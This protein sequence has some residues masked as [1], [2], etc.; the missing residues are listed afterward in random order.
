MTKANFLQLHTLTPYPATLLNRDDAGFAKRLPFG[1]RSRIRI[2]SQC[3]K[4]HWRS[5]DKEGSLREL[6]AGMSVRSRHIFDRLIATPLIDE[7][8]A[9]E[10]VRAVVTVLRDELLGKSEKKKKKTEK[11]EEDAAEALA[12]GQIIVLGEPEIA[13]L[14]DA[15]RKLVQEED[16]KE[17]IKNAKGFLKKEKKNLAALKAAA[18]LDAALFGRMVTS[19]LLARGNAAVHVAHA[20][21]V[22]AEEVES[23]YFSAVDELVAAAQELGSGH[24]GETELTSGLFYSYVVVD[25][26]LLV[27]NLS[28]DVELAAQVVERLPS[29]MATVSP[30]AKKG[31]TAPYAYSQM[32]LAELGA[33]QPR[34]LANAFLDPIS[35]K[36]G[37]VVARSMDVLRE[38]LSGYDRM[39]GK[40]EERRVA[41]LLEP[42]NFPAATASSVAELSSWIGENVR[43]S[44]REE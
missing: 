13:F 4:K 25:L 19:D 29:I 32:V 26:A 27:R 21:T 16:P 5:F 14:L 23:D 35:L 34:T 43:S 15:A 38:H 28:D 10:T 39:Y 8:F 20:F 9:E 6:G 31:S 30:G 17:A 12:T 2:S 40:G 11:G 3:L 41:S 36:E 42:E 33:R 7:G 44:F 24:I 22:H 37:A 1:G 18:G